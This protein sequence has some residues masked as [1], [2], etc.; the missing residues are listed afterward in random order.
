MTG[1]PDITSQPLNP[2]E[3][4]AMLEENQARPGAPDVPDC[5]IHI[6]EIKRIGASEGALAGA[7]KVILGMTTDDAA[8][9]VAREALEARHR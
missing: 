7:L 8:R 5:S 6:A 4:L 2:A 1:L 9:N 3:R